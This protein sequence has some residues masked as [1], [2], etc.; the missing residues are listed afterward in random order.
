[1]SVFLS[2]RARAD[3]D[4]I[5]L[6]AAQI[7]N[8]SANELILDLDEALQHLGRYP[9]MGKSRPEL[10]HEDLRSFPR[11]HCI[12]YYVPREPDVGVDIARILHAK[13]D[14]SSSFR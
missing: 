8:K 5:W 4:A 1:M 14:V 6:D 7:S 2:E 10:G 13:R 11:G 3:L 12:I 9:M